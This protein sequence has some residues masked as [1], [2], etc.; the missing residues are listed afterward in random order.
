MVMLF[1]YRNHFVDMTFLNGGCSGIFRS[2]V[3]YFLGFLFLLQDGTYA[4][5]HSSQTVLPTTL[6]YNPPLDYGPRSRIM[7]ART[8]DKIESSTA[9]TILRLHGGK[10]ENEK[11][12]SRFVLRTACLKIEA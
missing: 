9:M 2:S 6:H 8:S 11:Q 1:R 4:L 12:I 10:D 5:P 7:T 3:S